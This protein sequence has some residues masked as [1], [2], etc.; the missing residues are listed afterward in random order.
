MPKSQL[1]IYD[2]IGAVA[3]VQTCFTENYKTLESKYQW[4]TEDARMQAFFQCFDVA[5][6][7]V[8]HNPKYPE[9]SFDIDGYP[10][11]FKQGEAVMIS[12]EH[13]RALQIANSNL[14]LKICEHGNVHCLPPFAEKNIVI[15]TEDQD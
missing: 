2:I 12:W 5:A 9:L 15:L 7:G 14:L 4:K 6:K 8:H 10:F 11:R 13:I 1:S 3:D